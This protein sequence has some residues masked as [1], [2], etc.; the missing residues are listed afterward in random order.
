M[1]SS[2]VAA[3]L[4]VAGG[5]AMV[6]TLGFAAPK[7][8]IAVRAQGGFLGEGAWQEERVIRGQK[9]LL[10]TRRGLDASM[11]L[12]VR[13]KRDEQIESNLQNFHL[14]PTSTLRVAATAQ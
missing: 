14:Y 5:N 8:S 1:V 13:G 11:R 9:A 4:L 3:L 2:R 10:S 7:T 12:G 6:S